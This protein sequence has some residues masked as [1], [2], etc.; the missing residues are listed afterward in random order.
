MSLPSSDANLI[1]RQLSTSDCSIVED[2]LSSEETG[3]TSIWRIRQLRQSMPHSDLHSSQSAK[4]H[5]LH[6][7]SQS[8]REF[9]HLG[10]RFLAWRFR[11][12]SKCCSHKGESGRDIGHGP[13]SLQQV[14]SAKPCFLNRCWR[15]TLVD[16]AGRGCGD[17]FAR[18]CV[19]LQHKVSYTFGPLRV[20]SP[21]QTPFLAAPPTDRAV[22]AGKQKS[23]TSGGCAERVVA[24]QTRMC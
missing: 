2:L 1:A 16:W 3:G 4:R 24:F 10:D 11:E 21:R 6:Q 5:P 20:C 18:R 14:L 15:V 12:G 9:T 19:F 22:R 8:R 13:R 23:E 7:I 17:S